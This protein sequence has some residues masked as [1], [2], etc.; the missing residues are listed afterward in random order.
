[1]L[2]SWLPRRFPWRRRRARALL[3]PPGRST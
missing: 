2:P 3:L 1:L